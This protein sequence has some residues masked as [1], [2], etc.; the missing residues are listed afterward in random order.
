MRILLFML[1]NLLVVATIHIVL[2]LLGIDRALASARSGY[3]FD[4]QGVLVACFAWGM[5]G[6]FISLMLS[7]VM[8][9]MFMGVKVIDPN[10]AGPNLWLV[11]TVHDIAK[12]AELPAMP[13]VGIYESP[14][15]NAFATGP[16]K[17]NSLVAVSTGLLTQMNREELEGVIGHEIAHIKNGDMVTMTLL[18]GVVNAFVMFFARLIAWVVSSALA[19]NQ[20][21]D[22]REGFS[23]TQQIIYFVTSFVLEIVLTLLGMIVVAWFS[24]YRE[25]RADEGSAKIVGRSSMVAALKALQQRYE[26]PGMAND[27][28]ETY[29][30]AGNRK[31]GKSLFASHPPLEERISALMATA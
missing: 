31:K 2:S 26:L 5:I 13:E 28:L 19:G 29:K 1:T 23:G 15:V 18:Q 22:D 7:K 4:Y 16:S 6:S 25:F 27:R 17:R 12:R 9:K 30:I 14:D 21:S 10:A 3:G 24:R 20:N 11:N 8:A